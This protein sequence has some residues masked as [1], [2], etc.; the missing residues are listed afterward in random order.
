MSDDALMV[1]H[2]TPDGDV[3]CLSCWHSMETFWSE[4]P[5]ADERTAFE[6]GNVRAQDVAHGESCTAC[7]D[8][9]DYD[10]WVETDFEVES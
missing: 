7:G 1:G 10:E 5:T 9:W 6:G 8:I 3:V 4:E 2:R